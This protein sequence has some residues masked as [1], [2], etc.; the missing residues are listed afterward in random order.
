MNT[1]CLNLGNVMEEWA[2]HMSVEID[3]SDYFN[4]S[5]IKDTVNLRFSPGGFLATFKPAE[6]GISFLTCTPRTE[7]EIEETRHRDDTEI[8]SEG[9]RNMEDSLVL[10]ATDPRAPPSDFNRLKLCLGSF[11]TLTWALFGDYCSHYQKLYSKR[12]LMDQG[13]LKAI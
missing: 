5:M 8:R 2:T 9:N 10:S 4:K 11:C 12:K 6:K 7:Y 13:P 1:H 3:D